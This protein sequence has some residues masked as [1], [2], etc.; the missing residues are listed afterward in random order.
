MCW[1]AMGP[2]LL[3]GP[4]GSAVLVSWAI[5]GPLGPQAVEGE[6]D[7]DPRRSDLS[8]WTW[9]RA[10]ISAI[11]AISATSKCFLVQSLFK[12]EKNLQV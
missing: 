10:A 11:S 3:V 2:Q 9:L 7:I 1:N 5:L 6:A 4:F 12:Y 8:H